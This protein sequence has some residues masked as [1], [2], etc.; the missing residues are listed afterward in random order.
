M[1]F[2]TIVN[3]FWK[4]AYLIFKSKN[5]FLFITPFLL[6]NKSKLYLPWYS[7]IP[8]FPTP[9]KGKYEDDTWT[10]VSFIVTP[11]DDVLLRTFSILFLSSEK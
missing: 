1:I 9:P 3:L 7:P 6:E 4:G 10:K 5:V 11:P 2:L 8:L